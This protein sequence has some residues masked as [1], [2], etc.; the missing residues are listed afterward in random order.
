MDLQID[1]VD[2]LQ[3]ELN[4][5][6]DKSI[7]HR[8]VMLGS[9]ASGVTEIDNFLMGADNLSTI[10]CFREM[11]ISCEIIGSSKIVV[12]GRGLDGLQEPDKILDV[13][14]SGTTMRLLLGILSGQKFFSGLTGDDS[15]RKR[16]MKRVTAP[17]LKMGAN[18][19]GRVNAGFAPLAIQ[20][21]ALSGLEYQSPVASAQVKSALL[22]AGLYAGG[23]TTVIEPNKSRDHS[24]RMLQFFGADIRTEGLMTVIKSRPNLIGQ[25]VFVPGDISSASFFLVAGAIIPKS[26]ITLKGVGINPTRDGIIKVLKDMGAKLE[27]LNTRTVCGEPVADLVISTSNLKGTTIRGEI[28]PSLIDEIPIIAVAAAMAEG[29]TI[30]KDASELRVKE[31]DRISTLTVEL[32]KLGVDI[33][34]TSD[35]MIIQGGKPLKGGFYESH[36]DHRIA[37]SIAVA[38]MVAKGKTVIRGAE[39]IDVSFPNFSQMIE[40]LK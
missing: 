8:A 35:G 26:R 12:R 22:L 10:S 24:E 40:N 38:G 11:G 5:P 28:I 39:C 2:S 18:I 21:Q 16:P 15:I 23:S 17:L 34:A 29:E 4:I 36:G 31:T 19:L 3:G 27:I 30:I 13:G 25:K 6:G 33:K 1:P 9:L 32:S 14:N 37:M 7:S 20:G